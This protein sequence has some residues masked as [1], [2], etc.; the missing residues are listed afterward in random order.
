[1]SRGWEIMQ[2]LRVNSEE[3]LML[4]EAACKGKKTEFKAMA[5]TDVVRHACNPNTGGRDKRIRSLRPAWVKLV[6]PYLEGNA[7]RLGV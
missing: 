3:F 1:M 6:R 5:G 2:P 4:G 7:K